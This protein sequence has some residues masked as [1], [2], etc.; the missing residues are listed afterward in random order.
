M[1]CLGVEPGTGEWKAQTNPLMIV[2]YRI[3]PICVKIYGTN[4]AVMDTDKQSQRPL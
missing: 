4:L 1:V 2:N 3:F